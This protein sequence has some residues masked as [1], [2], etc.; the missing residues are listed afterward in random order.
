MDLLD[1]ES[2]LRSDIAGVTDAG[3]ALPGLLALGEGG[4]RDLDQQHRPVAEGKRSGPREREEDG[5]VAA[6]VEHVEQAGTLGRV[7]VVEPVETQH[8]LLQRRGQRRIGHRVGRLEVMR[9]DQHQRSIGGRRHHRRRVRPADHERRPRTRRQQPGHMLDDVLAPLQPGPGA[10]GAPQAH[11]RSG[12]GHRPARREQEG[13]QPVGELHRTV[14]QGD[15]RVGR[16]QADR[17]DVREARRRTKAGEHVRGGHAVAG[18][19]ARRQPRA[20]QPAGDVV[21]QVGVDA[22]KPRIELGRRADRHDRALEGV[23]PEPRGGGRQP[24]IGVRGGR[25]PGQGQRLLVGDVE[26]AQGVVGILVTRR[27]GAYGR[28]QAL[29]EEAEPGRRRLRR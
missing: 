12:L 11:G 26:A 21:L 23:E 7:E 22:S 28:A 17:P 13:R 14:R 10:A 9:V 29:V 6:L 19:Q 20:G 4:Q 25:S 27:G 8:G 24:W 16:Q 1:G 15:S 2:E 3:E 5:L 18:E